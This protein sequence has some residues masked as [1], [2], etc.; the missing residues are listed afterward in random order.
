M[1]L[2][3]S[4]TAMTLLF[5]LY[6]NVHES[7]FGMETIK[8]VSSADFASFLIFGFRDP[9]LDEDVILA[10]E[11]NVVFGVELFEEFLSL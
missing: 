3:R 8:K 5:G 2:L 7:L 6:F 4:V 10:I 9:L 11:C 1:K